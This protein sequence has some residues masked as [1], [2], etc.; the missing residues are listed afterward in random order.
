MHRIAYV[1]GVFIVLSRVYLSGI[2]GDVFL[3]ATLDG[4]YVGASAKRSPSSNSS[5]FDNNLYSKLARDELTVRPSSRPQLSSE[6]LDRFIVVPEYKLLFC[7]TEKVGCS[8]FNHLFRMLRILHPSISK[9][10]VQHLARFTWFRNTPEH[11]NL[12]RSHLE[13]MLVSSEWTKA[14]FFRDPATRFLSAYRSKCLRKEYTGLDHCGESFGTSFLPWR[15][16]SF[17]DALHK[18]AQDPKRVMR[19]EHFAPAAQFCG[20]LDDPATLSYYDFVHQ[21]RTATA[22]SDVRRLLERIGVDG[23]TSQYLISNV[24][25]TGG[26]SIDKDERKMQERFPDIA[27]KGSSTQ[28][29]GHNT[30]S[31]KGNVLHDSF[32]SDENVQYIWEGYARDYDLFQLPRLNLQQ[33][34]QAKL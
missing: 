4:K 20:G 19:N 3:V 1:V 15:T 25:E 12:T 13:D 29:K 6:Y 26:T 16:I 33:L 21:L 9:D 5:W 28:K 30:G 2:E 7:Y 34:Q 18:L 27:L 11:F 23:R 31:N 32:G 17:Q 10:E 8:M 22:A 14:V 24:V